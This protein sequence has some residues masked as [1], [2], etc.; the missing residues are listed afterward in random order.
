[1]PLVGSGGLE[2]RF[3]VSCLENQAYSRLR[4]LSLAPGFVDID[5]LV[6]TEARSKPFEKARKKAEQSKAAA[7]PPHLTFEAMSELNYNELGSAVLAEARAEAFYR[8]YHTRD[9]HT[10]SVQMRPVLDRATLLRKHAKTTRTELHGR[11]MDCYGD[12]DKWWELTND[13]E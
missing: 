11:W 9:R 2:R 4:P 13:L 8:R 7:R 10:R 3:A 1:M 5:L 6:L 12:L